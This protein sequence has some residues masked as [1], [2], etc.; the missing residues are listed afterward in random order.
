MNQTKVMIFD[1]NPAVHESLS[2]YLLNENMIVRNLYDGNRAIQEFKNFSPDIVILDIMMPGMSGTDICREIRKISNTPI[3]MLSAKSEEFDRI[4][5]LEL[6]AD[7]YVT[8]P[9]SPRELT[10]RIKNILRRSN[11]PEKSEKAQQNAK[12]S[13]LDLH[14]DMERYEVTVNSKIIESTPKEVE[15]LAYFIDHAEKVVSREQLINA[16]WGY[17]YYGNTRAVDN[18]I[19]RIRKK[20]ADIDTDFIINS[21]YGVGYKLEKKEEKVNKC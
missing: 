3:I 4:L 11:Q 17:E 19:K 13:Y 8:K 5:G 20:F 18:Q 14:V 6:G 7:D 16:L 12:K 9:F 15:I 10:V 2:K 21:I 1:D